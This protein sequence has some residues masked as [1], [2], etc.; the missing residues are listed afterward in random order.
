MAASCEAGTLLAMTGQGSGHPES[1]NAPGGKEIV[2]PEVIVRVPPVESEI[3][4]MDGETEVH[5]D[6]IPLGSSQNSLGP[7]L[8]YLY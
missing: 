3:S 6:S 8:R 7:K 2:M 1:L 4:T 5:V